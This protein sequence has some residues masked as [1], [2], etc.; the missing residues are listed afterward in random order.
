[1]RVVFLAL[2]I[3]ASALIVGDASQMC[4]CG[5][6]TWNTRPTGPVMLSNGFYLPIVPS[7]PDDPSWG[8]SFFRIGG[9]PSSIGSNKGFGG[10]FMSPGPQK[11]DYYT[12]RGGLYFDNLYHNGM[13][14]M[15]PVGTLIYAIGDGIIDNQNSFHSDENSGWTTKGGTPNIGLIVRSFT[16]TGEFKAVYGHMQASST[17]YNNA[18]TIGMIVHA[19]QYLGTVGSYASGSHLHFGIH[20]GAD[21]VPIDSRGWGRDPIAYWPST[22]GWADPV[23]FLFANCAVG[24]T[25]PAPPAN[26]YQGEQES[27]QYDIIQY[28]VGITDPS[29]LPCNPGVCN[30]SV[31]TGVTYTCCLPYQNGLYAIRT[32]VFYK[33]INGVLH[34]FDVT[35][36]TNLRS[37]PRDR[38]IEYHDRLM[39]GPFNAF[40]Y[41]IPFIGTP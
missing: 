38:W 12:N 10:H 4:P 21:N 25:C 24:H 5:N 9:M 36:S 17:A 28:M 18:S 30:R 16:T 1:M 6:P 41:K 19:G 39:N 32:M 3:V 7:N 34:L 29:L 23:R 13:D 31:D 26:A 27:V 33:Y 2:A 8:V 22:L 20:P 40:S 35:H 15:T 14:V 37:N 11:T